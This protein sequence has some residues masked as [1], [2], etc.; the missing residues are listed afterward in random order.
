MKAF[1]MLL[2]VSVMALAGCGSADAPADNDVAATDEA[3]AEETMAEDKMSAAVVE[4]KLT[5]A[6]VEFTME[7]E[8]AER[9][10][11]FSES[12]HS[13]ISKISKFKFGSSNVQLTV[14][15]LSDMGRKAFVDADLLSLY[16]QVSAADAAYERGFT[17]TLEDDDTALLMINKAEDAD[18]VSSI[19]AALK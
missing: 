17:I 1:K 11:V 18:L 12:N 16:N 4:S 19:L 2:L 7:D 13:A 8:T 10:A 6:G 5:E 9:M 14:V 15:D 3:P